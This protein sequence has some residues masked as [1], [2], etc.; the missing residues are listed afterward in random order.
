MLAAMLTQASDVVAAQSEAPPVVT[1]K[2]PL[3]SIV[4]RFVVEREP[5]AIFIKE[6]G[7]SWVNSPHHLGDW[8]DVVLPK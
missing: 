3:D 1:F 6:S 7:P 2:V 8:G 5:S 4:G